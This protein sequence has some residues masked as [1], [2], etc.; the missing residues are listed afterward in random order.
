MPTHKE[1]SDSTRKAI[2]DSFWELYKEMV[3]EKIT[4]NLVSDNA[5]IHRSTFY[6]YFQDTYAI[7][8]EIENSLITSFIKEYNNIISTKPNITIEEFLPIS[9]N[10][11]ELNAETLYYLSNAKGD[12]AFKERFQAT[13]IPYLCS[14]NNI[15]IQCTDDRYYLT[16]IMSILLTSLNFWY[17]HR[18]EYSMN[19][20]NILSQ[21]IL[22]EIVDKLKKP[23]IQ[24]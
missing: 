5:H 22:L 24:F 17:E 10:H 14:L 11:L 19:E 21:P 23:S 9:V 13:L 1:Q 18:N 2:I 3:I 6:R 8:E 7:L 12:A 4:V 16:L 20:L 15:S